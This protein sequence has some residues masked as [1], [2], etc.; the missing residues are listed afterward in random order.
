[1]MEVDGIKI[2]ESSDNNLL[3]NDLLKLYGLKR[4]SVVPFLR[5]SMAKYGLTNFKSYKILFDL[6]DKHKDELTAKELIVKNF[7]ANVR[8]IYAV[9]DLPFFI[10]EGNVESSDNVEE[11]VRYLEDFIQMNSTEEEVY[12]NMYLKYICGRRSRNFLS[13]HI[14]KFIFNGAKTCDDIKA[15]VKSL[16]EMT[17]ITEENILNII[18]DIAGDTSEI[19]ASS[20]EFFSYVYEDFENSPL[21][22][23]GDIREI[24]EK[25]SAMINWA[26]KRYLRTVIDEETN[27]SKISFIKS[28]IESG[29]I[30]NKAMLLTNESGESK[31]DTIANY[32]GDIKS[33]LDSTFIRSEPEVVE[34]LIA[35]LL[36]KVSS[37]VNGF[38]IV[39]ISA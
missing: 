12:G 15:M 14:D 22:E 28:L 13:E 9:D 33:V 4:I 37:L 31:H 36:H 21:K 29:A 17:E 25:F 5:E 10:S 27:A 38:K 19:T 39:K 32:V 1:M 34:M 35:D 20:A 30:N 8:G 2:S 6:M 3:T 24:N 11:D 7:I 18:K 26:E 16:L 23:L